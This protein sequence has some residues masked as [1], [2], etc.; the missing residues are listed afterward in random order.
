MVTWPAVKVNEIVVAMNPATFTRDMEGILPG[1]VLF[2]DDSIKLP[3]TR[4]DIHLYP[5]P[6]KQMVRDSDVPS[7]IRDYIANMVYVGIVAQILG[8]DMDH[9]HQ[10]LDFHFKGKQKPIEL[11]WNMVKNA[12]DWAVN[13]LTKNGCIF[14]KTIQ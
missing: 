13:N 14:R 11:N 4:Q 10:A 8:I 3:I 2:Y 1:G 5:M 7:N 9:I 6:V 12:Y